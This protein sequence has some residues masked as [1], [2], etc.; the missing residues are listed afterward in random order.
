MKDGGSP[1]RR[2]LGYA[3]ALPRLIA[4]LGGRHVRRAEFS[5]WEA[6]GL[7]ILVYGMSCVFV[8]HTFLRVVR[9]AFAQLLVLLLLPFAVWVAFLLLYYVNSLVIALL[10]Q[11]GL[12]SALTNNLFQHFVIMSLTTLLALFLVWDESGWM[13]LLGIFWLGLLFLNL[14][15]I[16]FLR[17]LHEP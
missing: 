2:E 10:R 5:R 9:P 6:Y 15:S 3:F 11:L 16:L 14:I 17:F 7:G 13:R 1:S 12:Y 4:R 8:A